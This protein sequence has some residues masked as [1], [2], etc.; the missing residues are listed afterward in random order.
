MR[1]NDRAHRKQA[2]SQGTKIGYRQLF[3]QRDYL[4]VTAANM[5]NRFGD[6]VDSIAFAWLV[7]AVTGNAA[8]SA[9]IFGAN[10]LPTILLMPFTGVLVERWN[11]KRLMILT[12]LIRGA[13]VVGFAALYLAERLNPWLM[14]LF[15]L[16]ISTAEAFRV[17]AGMAFVPQ[18]LE[19]RLYEFGTGLSSTLSTILQM[20]GLAAAGV[21]IGLWGMEAA[22]LTDA[23][24][25]FAS[26]GILLLVGDRE[27][28][29]KTAAAENRAASGTSAAVKRYFR[30]LR[31]GFFYMKKHRSILNFCMLAFL[32]NGLSAPVNSFQAPLVSEVLGR[33]SEFLSLINLMT[34]AGMGAAAFLYPYLR[35]RGSGTLLVLVS[36]ILYGGCYI[37]YP[38]SALFRE[39]E[40]AL[41]LVCGAV[42]FLN[43]ASVGVISSVLSVEFMK[44]VKPAFMARCSGVFNSLACA[45]I[46]L[47]S[48]ISGLS[49]V[50]AD[51]S[52]IFIACGAL[53]VVLFIGMALAGIKFEA[54]K[55]A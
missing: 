41:A 24:T 39:R 2:K 38:L 46:P 7:Y 20:L 27:Q 50:F 32:L 22:I 25:Y 19:K 15:T 8:W 55:E 54:P 26:A 40:L 5:I 36:G 44:A 43:G 45:A 53:S 17:P 35:R 37:A 23:L 4:K 48:W 42:S 30:D 52:M 33:G 21:I 51:L 34:M 47:V 3:S 14:L 31:E 28:E 18:I 9:V 10:Q 49:A 29:Q 16:C 13:L 12:D 1:E 6:S 11:K